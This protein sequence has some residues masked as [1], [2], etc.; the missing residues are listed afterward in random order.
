MRT[1][2]I[3]NRT[4]QTGRLI[5]QNS[6]RGRFAI[7]HIHFEPI[8]NSEIEIVWAVE[9]GSVP[10]ECADAALSAVAELFSQGGPYDHL[11]FVNTR[12]TFLAADHHPLDSSPVDYKSATAIALREALRVEG[13]YSEN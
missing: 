11:S 2:R 3:R 1:V 10:Q 4:T 5:G 13:E 8:A 6:N 7:V 12:I 9:S